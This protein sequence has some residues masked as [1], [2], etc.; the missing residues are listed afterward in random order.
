MAVEVANASPRC[1]HA[2]ACVR[3]AR[4]SAPGTPLSQA[5]L[6]LREGRFDPGT[7]FAVTGHGLLFRFN[8]GE[9]G[10]GATEF[11]VPRDRLMPHL[12]AESLLLPAP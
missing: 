4:Q 6:R 10:P 11:T 8:D 3:A 1:W 12:P 7:N 5:G 2:P 9:I